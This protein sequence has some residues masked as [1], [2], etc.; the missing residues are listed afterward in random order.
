MVQWNYQ[1]QGDQNEDAKRWLTIL[2]KVVTLP[3]IWRNTWGKSKKKWR[4]S[5]S[6]CLL[7]DSF[8][9]FTTTFFSSELFKVIFKIS[10]F[11]LVPVVDVQR[12]VDAQINLKLQN[13]LML[14]K[15]CCNHAYLIEYPLVP[16][17]EEF[18]VIVL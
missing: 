12:P 15:R 8:V 18:K 6:E 16:G 7:L 2:K 10:Y 9:K 1:P 5:R 14:L 13:V 17:T 11:S 4:V 3:V